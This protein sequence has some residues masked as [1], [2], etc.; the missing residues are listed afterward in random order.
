[1]ATVLVKSF[2]T[3]SFISLFDLK[4]FLRVTAKTFGK[5]KGFYQDCPNHLYGFRRQQKQLS[6]IRI[7]RKYAPPERIFAFEK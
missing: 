4:T 1:M 7:S 2:D 6:T 5:K 3:V